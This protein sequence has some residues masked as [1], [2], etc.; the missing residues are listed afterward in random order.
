M[1]RG[2]TRFG[3]L[4]AVPPSA[5][6]SLAEQ[7]RGSAEFVLRH[8]R[9]VVLLAAQVRALDEVAARSVRGWR[10]MDEKQ[11]VAALARSAGVGGATLA[12]ALTLPRTAPA[13]D[14]ANAIALLE[15]V[16]RRLRTRAATVSE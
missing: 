8:R 7:I 4:A 14:F 12:H 13:H 9:G 3:P 6:R 5:R 1:W 10:S 15:T 2:M 11:R 16:R